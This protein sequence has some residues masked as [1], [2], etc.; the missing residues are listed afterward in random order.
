MSEW[1]KDKKEQEWG[2]RLEDEQETADEEKPYRDGSAVNECW[3]RDGE[4]V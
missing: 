4:N 1:K 2:D 3:A